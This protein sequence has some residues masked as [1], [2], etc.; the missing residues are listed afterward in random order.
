MSSASEYDDRAGF[1]RRA[2]AV[3]EHDVGSV[4]R[5]DNNMLLSRK[6]KPLLEAADRL[7]TQAEL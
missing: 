4:L 1:A 7:R 5:A 2:V 6:I 3:R